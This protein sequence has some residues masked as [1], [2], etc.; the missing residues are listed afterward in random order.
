MIVSSTKC[1]SYTA[2]HDARHML[3]V[4]EIPSDHIITRQMFVYTLRAYLKHYGILL[5]TSH[6]HVFLI[7]KYCKFC[8]LFYIL[9]F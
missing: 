8:I 6:H 7:P 1:K 2:R 5:G 4:D 9:E 3:Y